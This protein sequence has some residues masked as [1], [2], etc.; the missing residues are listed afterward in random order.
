MSVVLETSIGDIVID[1]Y[2]DERPTCK[3]NNFLQSP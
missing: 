2:I 1:L 3:N